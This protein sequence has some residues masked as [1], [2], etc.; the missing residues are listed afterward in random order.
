MLLGQLT[1]RGPGAPACPTPALRGT[2]GL[3]CLP[4]P[5]SRRGARG[6]EG[7]QPC[8]G[9]YGSGPAPALPGSSPA[10]GL[11]ARKAHCLTP[12]RAYPGLGCGPWALGTHVGSW[13][14]CE[15]PGCTMFAQ[16]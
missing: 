9:S 14:L 15:P 8:R 5:D 11:G 7:A 10:G 1:G 4:A 6:E 3:L 13:G 2:R 12:C 16:V